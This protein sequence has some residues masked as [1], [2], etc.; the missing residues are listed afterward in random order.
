VVPVDSIV[1]AERII[2]A[3]EDVIFICSLTRRLCFACRYV[4]IQSDDSLSLSLP[5]ALSLSLS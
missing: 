2:I 4:G 1:V 5:L 3:E